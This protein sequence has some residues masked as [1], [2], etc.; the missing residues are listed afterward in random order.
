MSRWAL[1]VVVVVAC[2]LPDTPYFGNVPDVS[3][4]GQHLRFCNEPEPES[5][6]PAEAGTSASWKTVHEL[7]DG[8]T[9][10]GSD[11][12]LVPSLATHWEVSADARTFT[13]HLHDRGRWSNGRPITAHDIRFQAMRVLHPTT[14]SVNAGELEPI[15][16]ATLY[17]ANAV[18][19]V[20]H[21]VAGLRVGEV[22]E[23]V[24]VAG[25]SLADWKRA[26]QRWPDSNERRST[27]VLA[28]RDRD[29][30]VGEAYAHVPPGEPVQIIERVAAWSYV[31][32][33]H[34]DGVFGWVPSRDLD[35]EPNASVRYRVRTVMP[36]GPVVDIA[37]GA[38]LMTPDALGI[39]VPDDHTIV[40]QTAYPTPW[41][42]SRSAHRALLPTP[43]E[44]VS[45]WPR[46][47]AHV[48]R[49][50]SSGPMQ[51]VEWR[52]RDK[53]ELVRSPTYWN[54]RAVKLD[55]L[56]LYTLDDRAAAT[57][58]YFTGG[59]DAVTAG[60]I[61]AAFSSEAM[62]RYRD[63]QT[64]PTFSLYLLNLNT[65]KLANRHLRRALAYAVDR[66]TLMTILHIGAP[67][68]SQISVGTPIAELSD[69][70]RTLC[71]VTRDH[72]GVA[73]ILEPGK[74]CYVPPPGLDFDPARARA[75]LA[76]ARRE[77]GAAA[78]A[79]LV[80]KLDLGVDLHKLV[81]EFLQDQWRTILGLDV[82]IEVEEFRTLNADTRAG[83]YE[84]AR[85]GWGGASPDVEAEFLSRMLCAS[86][87]NRS[88]Y[89]SPDFEAAMLAV[90]QLSDR[91]A[92]R[93]AVYEAERIA[94]EDAPI[95]PLFIQAQRLMQ[96]PYVR[97]LHPNP[98]GIPPLHEVW[99]DPDWQAH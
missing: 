59:C 83:R 71:G 21:D 5:L 81:A 95:I 88:R 17:A 42:V 91:A 35:V 22:V 1:L 25:R 6:D 43:R 50:V 19:V 2:E 41:F 78:P 30:A 3:E 84:I 40:F 12:R 13:F 68:T 15:E 69:A 97:D 89:C 38:L 27:H 32:W 99:I 23:V 16:N 39:R 49:I 63:F 45:R 86:P 61:P 72:R 20:Q 48:G 73:A 92:R 90:R 29:A 51:L 82:E 65:Q 87:K 57:N 11:G 77:L 93:R 67:P 55:R 64:V 94:V 98:L 7:F 96:K 74:V 10:Y 54:A 44:A 76:L 62:S 24:A 70:E 53:I 37:A 4:R 33:N 75:E 46:Q 9:V 26:K 31:Y 60:V 56:T 66:E 52:P 8:L 28:L 14:A 47:W 85:F 79:K 58:L 18:R 34:D 80:M 36:P